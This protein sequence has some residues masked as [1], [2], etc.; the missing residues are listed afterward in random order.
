M[1]VARVEG[2]GNR[3]LAFNGVKALVLQDEN[4]SV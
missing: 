1:M 2:R 3:E 4:R